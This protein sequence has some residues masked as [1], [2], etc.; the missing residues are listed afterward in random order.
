MKSYI[1]SATF[2]GV[3]TSRV[4]LSYT[5]ACHSSRKLTGKISASASDRTAPDGA[6][7][8]AGAFAAGAGRA[9]A[10]IEGA[11]LIVYSAISRTKRR[12]MKRS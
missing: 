2:A 1:I 5:S 4:P 8:P 12:L 6:G 9:G 3:G 7:A 10:E 11:S